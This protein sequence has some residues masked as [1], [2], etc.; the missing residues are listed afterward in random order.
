LKKVLIITYYWPPSGGPGV[1]RALKFVKYLSESGVQPYVLTVDEAHASYPLVD[2]SLLQDIPANVRVVKTR[3]FEA[4]KVL[5]VFTSK[6]NIPHGGFA[7]RGKES[8]FHKLLRF[9]RGNF[10]IPDA[11]IGW[12]RYAVEAATELIEKEKIGTILVST[13]P[14]SSQLIGLKLKKRFPA[15]RWIADM[16]DPWTDIYYYKDLLHT[17]AAAAKDAAYEAQVLEAAD[18]VI[19]VSEPVNRLFLKKSSRLDPGKFHVIPNGF[20]EPDFVGDTRPDPGKFVFTYVG[21]MSAAYKPRVLFD[22]IEKLARK[23]SDVKMELHLVGTHAGAVKELIEDSHLSGLTKFI[24][25]VA[26][27]KAVEFMQRSD[28]LLL[29]IPDVENSEGILTGKLFEYL[30]SRRPVAAL[31]PVPGDAGRILA[32]C[33]AGKLFSRSQPAELQNYLEGLLE[34]WKRGEDT[35][36]TNP[37]Y[38]KYSRKELTRQLASYL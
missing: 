36:N 14:H 25:Q 20:D 16:R 8:V 21:T 7:N 24:P 4:L 10:F 5:S 28:V 18:R 27:A 9:I 30:G 29:V 15:L 23:H 13:P 12:I 26:H 17:G 32:E 3:S 6:K 1:Q 2:V 35:S 22:A 37:A 33:E 38:H 34:R 31:G 11:R 19:S